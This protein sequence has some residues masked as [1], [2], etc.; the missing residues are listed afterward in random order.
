MSRRWLLFLVLLPIPFAV[1]LAFLLPSG[2]ASL[3]TAASI[4]CLNAALA[5]LA[6]IGIGAVLLLA[7]H[8]FHR[9]NS[10]TR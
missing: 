1:G 6:L 10:E 4:S 7:A 9:K 8:R 3:P 5:C 2:F